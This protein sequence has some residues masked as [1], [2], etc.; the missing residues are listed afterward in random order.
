MWSYFVVE[1]FFDS[2]VTNE[3]K[4]AKDKVES[5]NYYLMVSFEIDGGFDSDSNNSGAK[6]S[7]V[8]SIFLDYN[9]MVSN[10]FGS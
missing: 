6:A 3:N 10:K 2:H 9:Y 4:I 5:S 1:G 7:K 8:R